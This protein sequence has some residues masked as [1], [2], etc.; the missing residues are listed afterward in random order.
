MASTHETGTDNS[1]TNETG[2]EILGTGTSTETATGSSTTTS[3]ETNQGET[4]S[5]SET[6]STTS[7]VTT[8]DNSITGSFTTLETDSE[9]QHEVERNRHQFAGTTLHCWCEHCT[10]PGTDD[11]T[12]SETGNEITG[13]PGRSSETATGG[14]HGD[15]HGSEPGPI[16]LVFRIRL[17]H[18]HADAD[19]QQHHQFVFTTLENRF[20]QPARVSDETDTNSCKTLRS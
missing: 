20:R 5:S 7:T 18:E 6:G 12:T 11:T 13:A 8:T 17:V 19:R 4:V 2:N 10:K 14:E 1:T 3:T 16:R 15:Q 9:V